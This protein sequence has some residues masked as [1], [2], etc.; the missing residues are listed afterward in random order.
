MTALA[1]T[2]DGERPVERWNP[3]HCGE[4]DMV[5]NSDGSWWHEGSRIT[6]KGLVELFASILRK[7]AD[8]V[9]YL[10]TPVEK[11]AIVVERA[12]FIATRV[13]IEGEGEAQRVFFTTNMDE[14]VEAGHDNP[15]RVE[16]D[17]E[18]L[19]PSPFVTVR[20]RLEASL[21][22]PVF[23]ELVNAAVEKDHQLGVFAGGEFFPLGPKGAHEI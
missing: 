18:T 6:R 5:I 20:G 23:Y 12:H 4:M 7:D 2:K 10:V 14:V 19:E 3:E 13:D 22:R 1:D 15:I 21:A 17:P 11:I 8:G 9:T 16:T